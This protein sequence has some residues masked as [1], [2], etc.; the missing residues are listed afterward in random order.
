MRKSWRFSSFSACSLLALL[1]SN[2]VAL[3]AEREKPVTYLAKH[4]FTVHT[5]QGDA[6]VPTEISVD[7]NSTH[8]EITRAAIVFHGK[9]RNVEGYFSA[10]Q[11]AAREAGPDAQ[12]TLLL[13]P[14]FLREE[15]AEAHHLP[16]QYLRWRAG[17]WSAGEAAAGPLPL[18]TFDVID[19]LLAGLAN[20]E[21]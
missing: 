21:R 9:G 16:K 1:F 4:S 20:R 8:P 12:H 15:D 2:F 5:A 6:S 19:A 18:S 7:L 14:Q 3:A 11:R 17:S 10:L 13:A